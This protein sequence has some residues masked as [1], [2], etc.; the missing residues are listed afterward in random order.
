[1]NTT[2]NVRDR[3]REIERLVARQKIDDLYDPLF[4]EY[5]ALLRF[6]WTLPIKWLIPERDPASD[7]NNRKPP[8]A[9]RL[10]IRGTA[11]ERFEMRLAGVR[12]KPL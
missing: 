11:A 4:V 8:R 9:G 10:R 1:M 2:A 7:Y 5:R 3:L 6:Y 12:Y